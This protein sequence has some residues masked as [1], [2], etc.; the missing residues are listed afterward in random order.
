MNPELLFKTGPYVSLGA[1]ALGMVVRCLFSRERP[2]TD[3]R[4]SGGAGSR[5][6]TL[7]RIG[8]ALLLVGHLAGLLAPRWILIW[9]ALPARLYLLES[10]AFASGTAALFGWAVLAFRHLARPVES[11]AADL[12]DTVFLS[13]LGVALVAGLVSA[14]FYRWSSSW[15]VLTLTPYVLS[16]LRG[17][18]LFGLAS[19][20]PFPVQLHVTAA[21][22]APAVAP[23][24]RLAPLLLAR[25]RR[26]M[27]ALEAVGSA[28][29]AAIGAF[30]LDHNPKRFI[31]PDE[32]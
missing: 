15:G 5:G 26:A 13:L 8:L 11:A 29:G 22:A 12:A 2:A 4:A 27:V 24:T 25:L 6:R 18:P 17:K 9:N 1:F 7:L 30:V 28:A 3:A 14:A 16:L 32:D 19:Q 10:T 20:L 23:Y 31:W 21:L